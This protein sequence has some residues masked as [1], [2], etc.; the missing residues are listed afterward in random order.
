VDELIRLSHF[1]IF[2]SLFREATLVTDLERGAEVWRNCEREI[3]EGGARV[4]AS[5]DGRLRRNMVAKLKI[6]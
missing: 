3:R 1:S 2:L 5:W 6:E 4:E